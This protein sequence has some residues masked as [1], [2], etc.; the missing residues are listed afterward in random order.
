MVDER[1]LK[2]ESLLFAQ[3]CEELPPAKRQR[4]KPN[5]R[6][7]GWQ[8]TQLQRIE[9]LPLVTKLKDR[10]KDENLVTFGEQMSLAARL[11]VANPSVGKVL[12]NRYKVVML[13]EYQ[14]T[15][16][17]QRCCFAVIRRGAVTAVGDPMQSIYGWRGATA[18][19]PQPVRH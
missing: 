8:E 16:H 12:R 17:A 18:A 1:E 13:D 19:K 11:A 7:L 14:D 15:S 4:K 3:L 5:Q 2:I 10:L 6:I 9:L